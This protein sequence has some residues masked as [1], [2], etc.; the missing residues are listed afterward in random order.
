M[1]A[2]FYIVEEQIRME[3]DPVLRMFTCCEK[4]TQLIALSVG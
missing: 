1:V 4:L 2:G 3:N